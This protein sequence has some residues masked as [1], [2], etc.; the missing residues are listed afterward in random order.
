MQE[1]VAPSAQQHPHTCFILIKRSIN[2]LSLGLRAKNLNLLIYVQKLGE[3]ARGGVVKAHS[4]PVQSI[5]SWQRCFEI[6]IE[7]IMRR[8]GSLFV[9]MAVEGRINVLEM[10]FFSQ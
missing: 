5:E 4:L 7:L 3:A 9:V 8:L 1:C 6:D 2:P 10:F